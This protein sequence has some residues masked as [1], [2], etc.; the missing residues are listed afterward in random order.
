MDIKY[1]YSQLTPGT[2][3]YYILE[4]LLV[5]FTIIIDYIGKSKLIS[6]ETR[7]AR[8]WGLGKKTDDKGAVG[9]F[10]G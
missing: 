1:N 3:R 10:S 4:G 9:N 8:D 5:K 2:R 6:I 7:V